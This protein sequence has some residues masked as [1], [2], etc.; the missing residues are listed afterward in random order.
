MVAAALYVRDEL[1]GTA[2]IDS[3]SRSFECQLRELPGIRGVYEG[4]EFIRRIGVEASSIAWVVDL[5]G[6]G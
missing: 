1:Q 4:L 2:L 5:D 3:V 6:D